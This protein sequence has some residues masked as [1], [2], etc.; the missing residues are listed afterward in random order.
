[1][2][3]QAC[4]FPEQCSPEVP[5]PLH[6]SRCSANKLGSIC[7]CISL[8]REGTCVHGCISF[9]HITI[10]YYHVFH[11]PF[12]HTSEEQACVSLPP[13]KSVDGQLVSES[14]NSSWR[15]CS[16]PRRN[17][18]GRGTQLPGAAGGSAGLAHQA[19]CTAHLPHSHGERRDLPCSAPEDLWDIELKASS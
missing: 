12:S 1:M 6:G 4:L 16:S 10:F 15:L 8:M 2:T 9:C 11:L 14:P 18:E 17:T 19:P 13:G 7:V 5:R 3:L